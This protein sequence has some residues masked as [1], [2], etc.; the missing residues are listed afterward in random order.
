MNKTQN[1]IAHIAIVLDASSSMSH[2]AQQVVKVAD[3]QI[4]YLAERSK[5]LDTETRVSVYT[6]ASRGSTQCLIF[7]KDVLRMPS[8]EG[9]YSAYGNTAL[10][11]ATI[12]SINDL[13]TTS[14]LYGEHSFLIYVITDGA[15]NNSMGLAVELR[16]E[17]S[18]LPDNFTLGV[19]VPDVTG[20]YS[21][22]QLGFPAGNI[23]VWD[24]GSQRGMERVGETMRRAT[25]TYMTGLATG[26][27]STRTLFSTG[28][29]AVN[30]VTV[31]SALVPL[32]H[33]MYQLI[34]VPRDAVIKE[35]VESTGRKYVTGNAYYEFTKGEKIQANKAILV[36]E[37]ATNQVF[38]GQAARDLI[39]LPNANVTVRPTANPKYKI[40]VQST[41]V[42]RNLKAGTQLLLLT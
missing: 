35:F 27:R 10:I 16:R 29:D 15:E 41:A 33:S 40:F 9:L 23:S 32:A 30:D 19:Y 37:K 36:M 42:N 4:A 24:T 6:F 31:K 7:D 26:I 38:T 13:K 34:P 39:G 11:D 2:H 25:D 20:V 5:Q 3:A 17:F 22:K 21:A 28:A 8:I 12:K 14:Q 1:V 18:I